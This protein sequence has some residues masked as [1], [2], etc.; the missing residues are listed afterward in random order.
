MSFII[1]PITSQA[2]EHLYGLN[3]EELQILGVQPFIAESKPGYPCRITLQDA[4]PGER[5]LLLNYVHLDTTSPYRASHALF[6]RDG[7]STKTYQADEIPEMISS[8]LL[9]VR[10]YNCEDMMLDADVV[11]GVN[12]ATELKRMFSEPDVQYTH[13][14]TAKRGCFLALVDRTSQ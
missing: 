5:V 9:S 8:R 6:V 11:E 2:F 12:V 3:D 1:K 13:I 14:H 7:A 4:E 10:A